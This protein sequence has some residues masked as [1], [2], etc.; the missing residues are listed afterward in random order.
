MAAILVTKEKGQEPLFKR[1]IMILTKGRER[2]LRNRGPSIRQGRN[3][4]NEK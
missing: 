3:A 1:I 2:R 4:S